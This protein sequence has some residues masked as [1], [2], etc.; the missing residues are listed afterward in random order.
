MK[1]NAW[2]GPIPRVEAMRH[3]GAWAALTERGEAGG[4]W[5]YRAANTMAMGDTNAVEFG[6]GAH[7]GLLRGAGCMQPGEALQAT[8]PPPRG[9]VWEGVV[10]DDHAIIARCGSSVGAGEAFAEDPAADPGLSR[11]RKIWAA[12][13]DAYDA[14]HLSPVPEKSL[15]EVPAGRVWGAWLDGE[16]G[17]VGAP[18]TRRA[19]LAMVSLDVAHLGWGSRSMRRQLTGLWVNPILYRRELLCVL[20]GLF[21]EFG[22][23]EDCRSEGAVAQL[24]PAQRDELAL[25]SVLSP[26]METNLRAPV[27]ARVHTSDASPAGAGGTVAPLQGEAAKEMWRHR[28]RRGFAAVLEQYE[29]LYR[30]ATGRDEVPS[31]DFAP[32]RDWVSEVVASLPHCVTQRFRFAA[33]HH[34]NVGEMR[35]RRAMLR[36][37]ARQPSCG[38]TRQLI[39]YDSR[40]TIGVAAKGRSPSRALNHEQRRAMPYLLGPDIQ[41]G[42]LWVD[43]KRNPA[44]HPSRGKPLPPPAEAPPWVKQFRQG[45]LAALDRRLRAPA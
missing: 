41:E 5:F 39:A 43:S 11:A 32:N 19:E 13:S 10:V 44:D 35:A 36:K 25:L 33:R 40:V 34:I 2:G 15:V 37:L 38:G 1:A 18:R 22:A 27:A 23:T 30:K 8:G 29:A 9:L 42:P 20:D 26:L 28:E 14:A 31:D 12:S 17:N 21:A 24:S 7:V 6:Q 3:P 4:E 16:A 45:D